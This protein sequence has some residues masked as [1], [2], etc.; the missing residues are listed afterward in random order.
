M[1]VIR[2]AIDEGFSRIPVYREDIDDIIGIVYAKD[3]LRCINE[4]P[5]EMSQQPITSFIRPAIFVP[6]S[7][8]CSDLFKTFKEKKTQMAIV[9]DEYGGTSGVVTME[10]LL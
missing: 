2:L 10:D 9:V 1:D 5:D 4:T 8:R 6:E 7:N 3:M